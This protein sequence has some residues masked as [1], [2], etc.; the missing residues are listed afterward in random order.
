MRPKDYLNRAYKIE[1]R[2]SAKLYRLE[3]LRSLA[4]RMTVNIQDAHVCGGKAH[5]LEDAIADI[6]ELEQDILVEIN[7]LLDAKRDVMRA[8]DAV[9]NIECGLLLEMRYLCYQSWEQ[10]ADGLDCCVDNVYKLHRRA[11]ALIQ[12]IVQ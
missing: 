7:G 3:M 4:E 10:I 2:I 5:R 1:A 12:K 8:I 11:L 9:D 6:E